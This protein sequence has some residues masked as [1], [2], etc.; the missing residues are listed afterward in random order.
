MEI[1][2]AI[3]EFFFGSEKACLFS[4]FLLGITIGFTFGFWFSGNLKNAIV[5]FKCKR[6]LKEYR[7]GED[8]YLIPRDRKKRKRFCP[9]CFQKDAKLVLIEKINSAC[10]ECGYQPRQSVVNFQEIPSLFQSRR[11][12]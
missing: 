5:T 10:S 7:Y 2:T 3:F 4:G 11:R 12:F 8:G 1:L 6:I 9:D